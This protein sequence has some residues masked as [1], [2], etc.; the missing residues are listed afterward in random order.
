MKQICKSPAVFFPRQ[1][2]FKKRGK[3]KGRER[4]RE[5]EI[6]IYLRGYECILY[7]PFYL[8]QIYSEMHTY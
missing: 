5:I 3:K 1:F 4:E 8:A 2:S 7:S 6:L